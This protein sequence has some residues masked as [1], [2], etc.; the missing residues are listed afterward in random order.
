MGPIF[1][2]IAFK[3][4]CIIQFIILFIDLFFVMLRNFYGVFVVVHLSLHPPSAQ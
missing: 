4:L 3:R 2:A 1:F